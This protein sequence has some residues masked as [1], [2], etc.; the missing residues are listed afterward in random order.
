[1]CYRVARGASWRARGTATAIEGTLPYVAS[2][3]Q[4]NFM[5]SEF[6]HAFITMAEF[7]RADL[8]FANFEDAKSQSEENCHDPHD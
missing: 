7:D 8:R 1:M 3:Q 6:G 4:V 5:G 2:R